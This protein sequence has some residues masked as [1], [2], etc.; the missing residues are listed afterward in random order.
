MKKL[1]I[2]ILVIIAITSTLN[3][4]G[5]R[6]KFHYF[7]DMAYSPAVDT[8]EID[9]ITGKG[10]NLTP[11]EESV[12]YGV[13]SNSYDKTV[14]VEYKRSEDGSFYM[15]VPGINYGE[16]SPNS[17]IFHALM[18]NSL[19]SPLANDN[20]TFTRGQDRYRIYCSPCHGLTGKGDGPVK[21]RFVLIRPLVQI[22]DEEVPS[23]GWSVEQL[24]VMI[25]NGKGVMKGYGS[26]IPEKDR[27]A[28]AH[29]V[30]KL[31]REAQAG[32]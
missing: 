13:A 15:V 23:L 28:I 6:R 31:Q 24:F 12:P 4:N 18:G 8:S 14:E 3:C 11:P 22:P 5:I 16:E 17:P 1:T 10:G 29:Y 27:W 9:F 25:S 26:Q 20:T 30:K 7:M 32:R 21:E 19:Q 2:S